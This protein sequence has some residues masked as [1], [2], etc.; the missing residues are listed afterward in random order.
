MGNNVRNDLGDISQWITKHN[1][2]QCINID[3]EFSVVYVIMVIPEGESRN[4]RHGILC[5]K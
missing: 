4:T 3:A 2:N 5:E 1:Q